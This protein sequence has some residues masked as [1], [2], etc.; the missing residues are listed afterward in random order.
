ME[1]FGKLMF[2]PAVIAEQELHGSRDTYA[3]MTERPAPKGLGEDEVAFLVSRASF[4][5]AT[6]SETGWPYVQHRGGPRG[7][8]KVLDPQTIGFADYRG[9][10][11]YVSKGHLSGDDRVSL[12][13]MDYPRKARLKIM[14]HATMQPAE[15]A[16]A[17]ATKLATQDEGRVERLVTIR[18]AA[19]DWNCPQFITPRFDTTEMTA[20]VG[21]EIERLEARV[22]ELE[23]ELSSA[24]KKET[25]R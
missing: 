18:I 6:V 20:L 25:D 21:P 5:M 15:D 8:L 14:G 9:N 19:F 1:T 16:P 22:A 17:L 2:T 11:Q 12:F 3:R 24:K 10:R 4:Y 7:F 23:A 13:F